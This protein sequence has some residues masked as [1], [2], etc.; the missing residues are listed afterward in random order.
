LE[1]NALGLPAIHCWL[2]PLSEFSSKDFN[3]VFDYLYEKK[4]PEGRTQDWIFHIYDP[5]HLYD[6]LNYALDVFH[7]N[8]EEYDQ[9]STQAIKHAYK[10]DYKKIY[11]KLLKHLNIDI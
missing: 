1:A 10:W 4:V 8:P 2:P 7:D 3:F 11:P 6:M 5:E 9:Y